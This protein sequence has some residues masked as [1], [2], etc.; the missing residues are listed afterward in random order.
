M[1]APSSNPYRLAT[2]LPLMA[3]LLPLFSQLAPAAP[4][5]P[6]FVQILVKPKASMTE[7][8][9]NSL[10]RVRGAKQHGGVP[11]L[12]VR[13]IR[14]PSVAAGQL[15][16]ALQHHHDVEYAEPDYTAEALGTAN[17]PYFAQ[18]SQWHLSTIQ[19]PAA[20]D[21]T[22][23]SNAVIVAV[24]DSGVRASHPDL[25]G[26]VLAG[27]DFIANDADPTDENG[28]G[29]AVAG[30]VS[31]ATNNQLGVAGVSWNTPILPVRVL[32]ANGSGSYSSIASGITYSADKG[33]RVINLSLGGTSSSR[34]L[35]DAV[36]YA[37][38]KQAVL[39]AAAGN[40]GNNTL[41][42]PAAC[43]NVVAVSATDSSD[44]RPGWSNFGSYVDV[45]APGANIISLSGADQY[46]AW[47]GT[48]FSCPV[49][50]GVVALAASANPRLT[51]AQLV[52]ILVKNTDDI[53][54]PGYDVYYGSGRV[55][56]Y[57]AAA[58]AL[59]LVNNDVTAPVV[60]I[61]SPANGATVTSTQRINVTGS[62]NVAVTRI[63][64]YI[65]GVL[66]G[67]STASTA[68]FSWSTRRVT[69]GA[70]KLE[71]YAYDAAANVGVSPAITVWK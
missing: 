54:S 1:E 53:G 40:N 68:S 61:S 38:N 2:A 28:H 58:A 41:F 7:T 48:S 32:D 25:A 57:R 6:E 20:W 30:T 51:N 50:A 60:N 64:L 37:W 56:A 12:D 29:T 39:I 34:T 18:A 5:A 8:T 66:F 19:A 59:A 9:L 52:D 17:D 27:Y 11:A 14:V 35:Q 15:L 71:A 63:E 65:D 31:P 16:T 43:A 33:A 42:Y 45:S 3:A 46:A 62:D 22:T 21:I 69:R 47:N 24:V 49:A 23:G 70:H 26:K 67:T 44:I 36:N 13:I 4:G 10:L 55:N